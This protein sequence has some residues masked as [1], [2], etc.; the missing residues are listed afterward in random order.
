MDL[1]KRAKQQ[2]PARVKIIVSMVLYYN[3]SSGYIPDLYT[4]FRY[5]RYSGAGIFFTK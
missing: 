2:I 5:T 4:C 1:K 3:V